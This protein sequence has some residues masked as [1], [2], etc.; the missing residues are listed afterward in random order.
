MY[1]NNNSIPVCVHKIRQQKELRDS[2]RDD[3]NGYD[4]NK[5]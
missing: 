2:Q 3:L 1:N 5:V 4:S